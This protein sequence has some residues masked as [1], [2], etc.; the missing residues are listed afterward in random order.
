ML[1][2]MPAV[3]LRRASCTA[4]SV[5]LVSSGSLSGPDPVIEINAANAC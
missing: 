2:V 3:E 5:S 1:G 4:S